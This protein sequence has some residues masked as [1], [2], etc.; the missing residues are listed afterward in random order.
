MHPSSA[1][2]EYIESMQE[3]M[4]QL[5]IRI[6]EIEEQATVDK[7]EFRQLKREYRKLEYSFKKLGSVGEDL[8]NEL[9]KKFDILW[10]IFEKKVNRFLKPLKK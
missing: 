6:N 5:K 1:Y 2:E 8:W 9:K 4:A 10:N 7:D 3:R